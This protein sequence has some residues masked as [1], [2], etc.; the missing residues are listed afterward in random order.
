MKDFELKPFPGESSVSYDKRKA[1]YHRV[2][3]PRLA[4]GRDCLDNKLKNST[5]ISA[6]EREEIDAFWAPY[7]TPEQRDKFIDYRYYD[8]YKKVLRPG[9][10]LC[11]YMPEDFYA[12][13][14]DEYFG[15]PQ[16]S[17]P[18][19]D[20]NL[21]DLYY[22]DI[23]RP[24]TIFRKVSGLL[25][26]EKYDEITLDDVLAMSRE[27]GEVIVKPTRFTRSGRGLLFWDSGR[28]DEK[29]L[30][31]YLQSS[32]D[33]VC[34]EVVKQHPE[35]S[36]LNASSLNTI[37][38]MTMML[39]GKVHVLSSCIRMGIA[40]SKVDNFTNGGIGSGIKP[41]G[42]LKNEAYDYQANRYDKH[43]SGTIFESVTIP[44]FDEC[45]EMVKYLA[46]RIS[47]MSRLVSWDLAIDESGHPLIIEMNFA[48]GLDIHQLCNGPIYR[49]MTREVLDEV[50]KNAYTLNAILKSMQ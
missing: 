46:K 18:T 7:L 37:R 14:I 11:E 19:D 10:K 39:H 6:S 15:N 28:N 27:Q 32:G 21:Y 44:N 1:Y 5:P 13:F 41:N 12:L 47:I 30:K 22:H 23:K 36:R 20:K 40:G 38:I 4:Y 2:L 48:G 29:E 26:D 33:V 45:I 49:D 9:E 25:L 8:V 3:S 24:R 17:F 42:Q 50:F 35:L 31:D 43:P 34:Q 16:H